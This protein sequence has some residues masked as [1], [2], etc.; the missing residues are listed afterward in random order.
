MDDDIYEPIVLQ[1]QQ[2]KQEEEKEEPRELAVV[3]FQG[4]G[5]KYEKLFY[6]EATYGRVRE[7]EGRRGE[8]V[9]EGEGAW[10][11][12][13]GGRS[14]WRGRSRERGH[15]VTSPLVSPGEYGEVWRG[16]SPGPDDHSDDHHDE[17]GRRGERED[18]DL[19]WR[20]GVLVPVVAS[21]SGGAGSVARGSS[22]GRGGTGGGAARA[23]G[24]SPPWGKPG[25]E[26]WRKTNRYQICLHSVLLQ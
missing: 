5:E 8:R 26:G 10:S 22:G 23:W 7:R 1:S 19:T 25:S 9:Q 17:R 21:L 12:R 15:A 18:S 14:H 13:V 20:G 4:L 6:D 11:G 2:K 24:T 3:S 16:R